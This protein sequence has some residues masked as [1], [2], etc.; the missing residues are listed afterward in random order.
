MLGLYLNVIASSQGEKTALLRYESNNG[1]KSQVLQIAINKLENEILLIEAEMETVHAYQRHHG[2]NEMYGI[3]MSAT[4]RRA[5][6][7]AMQDQ[8]EDDEL[9]RQ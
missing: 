4:K 6:L 7:Q 1:T 5:H 9:R 3:E 2:I 8:K